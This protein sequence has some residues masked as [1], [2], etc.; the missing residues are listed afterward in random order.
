MK[1]R[2]LRLLLPSALAGTVAILACGGPPR[3]A[4]TPV[5]GFDRLALAVGDRDFTP[6]AGRRILL[7]PGHGGKYRGAIGPSGLAEAD[8]NL[9]VALYLRGLLEW[10]GATVFM[11]RT[12][13]H[14]LLTSADS[15]LASDLQ[16]RVTM[17]DS[18]RPDVFL[19][20]HHNS[21]ASRDP[22][23]NETQ[24]YYPTGRE[25]A[26][27]DLARCIHEHL[28]E[29]LD[30]A[31]ARIMAGNF[32][33]LR[34]APVPA[35]LGEPAM[36]SNPVIEGRLT[37]A[38][39]QDLEAKAYFLGLLE[40][41]A[42]GAPHLFADQPDT[43]AAGPLR[44]RFAAGREG[45]PALDPASLTLLLDGA[46]TDPTLGADAV[47]ITWSPPPDLAPGD[48]VV[49]LRARNLRGRAAP[50]AVTILAWRPRHLEIA[51]AFAP[52]TGQTLVRIAG[53][54]LPQSR[55]LVTYQ[56]HPWPATTSRDTLPSPWRWQ[57]LRAPTTA[58]PADFV[59]GGQWRARLDSA[60]ITLD[61][62]LV[63]TDA[64]AVPVLPGASLWLEADG[65]LPL[66]AAS[67]DTATLAWEPLLPACL[68]K[69]VVIDP[70]GGGGD[71]QG[72]GKLGTRGS[73]VNLAVAQRLAALLRGVGCTVT[74]ARSAETWWPDEVKVQRAN[75]AHADLYLALARG[76]T[77][78]AI[79]HPG[80]GA[81]RALAARVAQLTG[82][83]VREGWDYVLRHTACP[84]LIIDLEPVTGD[85]KRLTDPAL[86][87][88]RAR[89]M[90]LAIAAAWDGDGVL[91]SAVSLPA[92]LAAMGIDTATVDWVRWDGNL[93]WIPPSRGLQETD[94]VSLT[95]PARGPRHMLEVH[96]G[97][98]WRLF[99]L[100]R[101]DAGAWQPRLVFH[102]P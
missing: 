88:A 57:P 60:L 13:D 41:F 92:L 91:T 78:A 95:L 17:A 9:G 93:D 30:I 22:R 27:L 48:H 64:P 24:T 15:T 79:H 70:R 19:S 43:A 90:L 21:T 44:W 97:A 51:S 69:H 65:A 4:V 66:V 53:L 33:V 72:R 80:S 50:D 14:D 16:A 2:R 1:I 40:Y 18:L 75:D 71:E 52:A 11:T 3:P 68:G 73:D 84:A 77:L 67:P 83:Q 20:I 45:D 85:E 58:W 28:V 32:H 81:G 98:R 46:R 76:D 10:A 29:A 38:A 82:A 42:G 54:D 26:D 101:T 59:P 49:T 7:D 47:A 34:E 96:Q 8:V 99:T 39:S 87:N 5:P 61:P 89:S 63:R 35:V 74:L 55:A 62:T 6:L 31:P 25:G 100:V 86:Q 94:A 23:V 37:L 102:G 12:A 56:W 36:I